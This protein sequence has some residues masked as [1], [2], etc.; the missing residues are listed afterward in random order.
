MVDG[1]LEMELHGFVMNWYGVQK[2]VQDAK[3]W[4]RQELQVLDYTK[5]RYKVLG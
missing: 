5:G 1:V 3:E 2:L 4:C